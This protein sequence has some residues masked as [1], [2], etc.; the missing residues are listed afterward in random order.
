VNPQDRK[1]Y[2]M[3]GGLFAVLLGVVIYQFTKGGATAPPPSDKAAKATAKTAGKAAKTAAGKAAGKSAA[4]TDGA[5]EGEIRF[6]EADVDIDALLQNIAKVNFDY[7][8]E[9]IDRDP[10]RP[11]VGQIQN[12]EGVLDAN[13]PA[14]A[15]AVLRKSVTGI[16]Y[17][18]QNPAAV[19]DDEVVREGFT[20]PGGVVVDSIEPTRVVFRVGDSLVPVQIKDLGVNTNK[21]TR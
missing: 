19:V 17:N 15:V 16:L 21:D 4:K 5:T 20:Y 18:S 13:A 12:Q 1:K 11:L 3:L 14:S 9:R 6:Q 10:M 7:E 2:I 8:L